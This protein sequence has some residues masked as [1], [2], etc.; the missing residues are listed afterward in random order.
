MKTEEYHNKELIKQENIKFSELLKRRNF[1]PSSYNDDYNLI[2]DSLC[3]DF[4]EEYLHEILKGEIEQ[5]ADIKELEIKNIYYSLS[6]SQGDGACFEATFYYRGILTKVS[7]TGIYY[8]YNSKKIEVLDY[9]EKLNQEEINQYEE[10]INEI[11]VK[12]CRYLEQQGYNYIEEEQKYQL[13]KENLRR[14]F[15]DLNINDYELYDLDIETK[16][17]IIK[18]DRNFKE[19]VEVIEGY[20]IKDFDI[21]LNK[22]LEINIKYVEEV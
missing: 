20:Y 3:Y 10:E 22:Y 6:Y 13:D 14:V 15:D 8:H 2:E 4:L 12:I 16:K 9:D 17:D 18:Y 1:K 5:E 19:Y 7:H 11:Y 21:K